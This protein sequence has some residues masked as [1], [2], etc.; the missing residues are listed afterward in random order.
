MNVALLSGLALMAQ[1]A[2]AGDRPPTTLA[3]DLPSPS[4]SGAVA[5]PTRRIFQVAPGLLREWNVGKQAF[6]VNLCTV[7]ACLKAPDRSEGSI[8]SASASYTVGIDHGTGQAYWRATGA[9]GLT[10]PKGPCRVVPAPT[11][12]RP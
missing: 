11:A 9:S 1:A 6:G 3:C 12:R 8:T 4:V 7:F 10:I 2:V 5:K